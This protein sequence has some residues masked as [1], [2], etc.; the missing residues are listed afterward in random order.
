MT[1]QVHGSVHTRLTVIFGS[2]SQQQLQIYNKHEK[3]FAFMYG[4]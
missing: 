3:V 4:R 2:E 1:G